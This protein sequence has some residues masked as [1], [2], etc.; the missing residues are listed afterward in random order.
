[1]NPCFYPYCIKINKFKGSCNTIND[2]Y[3]KICV[4]DNINNT[5]DKVFNLMSGTN[6][7]RHIRWHKTCQCRYRLNASVC[8]N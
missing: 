6:E 8:T 1:M 2:P 3:P 7:T 4:P 5:N